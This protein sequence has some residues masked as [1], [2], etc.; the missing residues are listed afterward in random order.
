MLL[1]KPCLAFKAPDFLQR[2]INIPV[3]PSFL[4]NR[5]PFIGV[6]ATCLK[7]TIKLKATKIKNTQR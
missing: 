7:Q 4:N 5:Q 6:T 1:L 2:L 3:S